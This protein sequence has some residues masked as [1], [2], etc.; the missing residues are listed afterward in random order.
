MSA[1]LSL[2]AVVLGSED[3][4]ARVL[5]A[6]AAAGYVCVPRDPTKAMLESAWAHALDE[7][8]EGVWKSMVESAPQ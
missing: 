5:A 7:D 4:A 8:A 2:I 1:P 3:Q 6:L